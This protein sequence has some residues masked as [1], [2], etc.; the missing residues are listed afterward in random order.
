MDKLT[1]LIV[2]FVVAVAAPLAS[3]S[4]DSMPAQPRIG[5]AETIFEQIGDPGRGINA[6]STT[7][8]FWYAGTSNYPS[9]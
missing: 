9:E 3:A 8:E 1:G 4:P 7:S 5:G 2:G 6:P